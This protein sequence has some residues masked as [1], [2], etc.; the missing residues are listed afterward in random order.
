[1]TDYAR[2]A[3]QLA[4]VRR[5]WRRRRVLAGA[6]IVVL[7]S[8]AIFTLVLLA[9][10]LYQPTPV[11]RVA[12]FA[13]A[14]AAIAALVVRHIVVHLVR[15]IPDAQ[16]ALYVEEHRGEFQGALMTAA[17]FGHATDVSPAQARLIAAAMDAA[18]ARASKLNMRSVVTLRRF[19]KYGVAAAVLLVA[20]VGTCLVFPQSVGR[21][22]ARVLTPWRVTA[23]DLARQAGPAG[24]PFE[25]AARQPIVFTLS[26]GDV[27][28]ASGGQFDLETLLSRPTDDTVR[29]HFR[30]VAAGTWSGGALPRLRPSRFVR[31]PTTS[32][33]W[34]TSSPRRRPRGPNSWAS[35][36]RSAANSWPSW[37]PNSRPNASKVSSA[38]SVRRSTGRSSTGTM[39]C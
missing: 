24:R 34:P 22:A 4:M 18:V 17:E 36:V 21:H 11:V 27:R 12:F 16:V 28:L 39:S 38:R 31:P 2:V 26:Q 14:L 25:E 6:A 7:E 13:V 5:A 9:D 32:T 33:A 37:P 29:L 8:L 3:A 35:S 1:M 23:E 19:R 30:S 15:R 10:W 20:Y